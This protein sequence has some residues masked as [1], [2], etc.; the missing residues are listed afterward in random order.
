LGKRVARQCVG[1]RLGVLALIAI[2]LGPVASA[3]AFDTSVFGGTDFD[4][5]GQGFAYLGGDVEQKVHP[6][7]SLVGRLMPNFLTYKFRSE[8]EEV[9]ATSPGGYALLGGKGHWGQTSA[10]LLAGVEIRETELDPDVRSANIRGLTAAPVVQA[11]FDTWLPSRTNLNYFGSFSGTDSFIYQKATIKQQLTN[12]DYSR[13]NTTNAGLEFI[14]GRNA[15]FEMYRAGVVLEL[16]R[17]PST[18]SLQLHGG[19]AHTTTFGSGFYGGVS[20][21]KGF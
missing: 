21:Y 10:G 13:P 11:D 15:D 2:V 17:I 3:E 5:H 1:G 8:G 12:L 14:W 16:F 4:N 6:N 9:K 18:L 7:F 20:F 19:Y